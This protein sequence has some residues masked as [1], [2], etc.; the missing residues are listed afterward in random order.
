MSRND[1]AIRCAKGDE[2]TALIP[3]LADLRIRIFAVYPYL[4]IGSVEYEKKYLQQ[5]AAA[6]DAVIVTATNASGE[7]VGCATGSALT[8][9]NEEFSAPLAAAGFDLNSIFYFGESVLDA[10]WRGYGIGH[11]FFDARENHA[12][13]LGYKAAC[14]CAVVRST[15][16]R[17]RP[18]DYSSLDTFWDKRGYHCLAGVEAIY[19]WP[20]EEGGPSLPHSMAY[21][22]KE[23]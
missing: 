15:E 8:G 11:A 2:V 14:F 21:W 1:V 18:K 7:I 6:P 4:Y 20:E 19:D 3:S 16:D 23:F 5:F 10:A 22:M 9:H 17:R 13:A 12:K